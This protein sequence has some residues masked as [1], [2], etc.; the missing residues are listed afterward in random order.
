[1]NQSSKEVDRIKLYIPK[2]AYETMN[3]GYETIGEIIT[4]RASNEYGGY[5]KYQAKGGWMDDKN[6]MISENVIVIE[7]LASK[8]SDINAKAWLNVNLRTIKKASNEYE[9]MGTVNNTM[10]TVSE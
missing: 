8:D 5:T 3:N 2:G 10:V 6:N 7:I 4:Q 9:V 1:M